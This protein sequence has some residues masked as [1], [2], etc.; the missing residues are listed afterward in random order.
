VRNLLE[1]EGIQ[2]ATIEFESKNEKCEL[3]NCI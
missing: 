3:E 2:H 1:S